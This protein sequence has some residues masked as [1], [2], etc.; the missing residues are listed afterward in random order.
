MAV[1]RRAQLAAKIA[2]AKQA[3]E[4]ASVMRSYSEIRAP[5]AGVITEKR[6]EPGQLATPGTPLLTLEQ[7]GGYRLE[8][9]VEESLLTTVRTAQEVTVIFDAFSGTVHGRVSEI[10]PAVDPSS[11]T[12]L[13]KVNLPSTA[14]LRSG[15]FGRLRVRRAS[16]PAIAVPEGAISQ[17]GDILSLF[18]ADGGIAR[19][20]MVTTGDRQEGMVVILSGLQD[21]DKVIYPRPAGLMDG[22]RVEVRR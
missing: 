4:S 15:M 14:N 18:V 11:R 3:V 12:F 17:R 6:A 20:R 5:Y 9:P 16:S 22:A 13:V 19:S 2:Q 8:A 10:V 7:S 21:G 1:S